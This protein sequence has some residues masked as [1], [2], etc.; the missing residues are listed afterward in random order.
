MNLSN[1]TAV[2]LVGGRG[3]PGN[4]DVI[5]RSVSQP[6]LT[7]L[8]F[9][10]YSL[11]MLAEH[12]IRQV[13]L[14]TDSQNGQ[15]QAQLGDSYGPIKLAYSHSS[16]PLGT[17]GALA[18]ASDQIESE[19]ALV[20]HEDSLCRF[21]LLT[22]LSWHRACHAVGTV[23]LT[24]YD[25][26][27]R[28]GNVEVGPFGQVVSFTETPG[29]TTQDSNADWTNAGIYLLSRDLIQSL[30]KGRLSLEQDVFPQLL[31]KGLHALRGGNSFINTSDS[32]SIAANS[33]APKTRQ[34][35]SR[36]TTD[37]SRSFVLLD[38]DGVLNV[39][40]SYLSDPDDVELLPGVIDGLSQLRQLGLGLA[41]VT[42]QSGIGRGYFTE[43]QMHAVH[44]ELQ[45]QLMTAN[46]AVDAIYHCPHVPADQC[47]CRKPAPGLVLKAAEELA[48]RPSD[49][50]VIGDKRSDVDLGHGVGAITFLTSQGHGSSYIND[51][52]TRPHFIIDNLPE[53]AHVIEFI[54]SNDWMMSGVRS[55]FAQQR[56]Y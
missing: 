22:F 42:N 41:V 54:L 3:I 6:R 15:I 19:V 40:K 5:D 26:V 55:S 4:S 46:I 53:A 29:H 36:S 47:S 30:P 38:R 16:K 51:K 45:R 9:A 31:G 34:T 23:L 33:V 37:I 44:V 11:D 20:L 13:V 25:G 8:P 24:R 21:D 28:H 56:L 35:G 48:F 52:E 32:A 39:E 18:H 2:V 17:G 27:S 10:T 12:G 49:S 43:Q 7:G 14:C 1:I 50:F